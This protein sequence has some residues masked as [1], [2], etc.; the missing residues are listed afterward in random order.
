MEQSLQRKNKGTRCACFQGQFILQALLEKNIKGQESANQEM[1][2]TSTRTKQEPGVLFHCRNETSTKE[3]MKIKAQ[4][5]RFT[6]NS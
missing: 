6:G 3:G 4:V 1:R 5:Q 2:E